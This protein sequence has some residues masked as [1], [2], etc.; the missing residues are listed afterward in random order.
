V[1]GAACLL[2]EVEHARPPDH[3]LLD[4]GGCGGVDGAACEDA[5]ETLLAKSPDRSGT[6]IAMRRDVGG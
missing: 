6:L 3:L 2:V 1:Q 5:S 4:L